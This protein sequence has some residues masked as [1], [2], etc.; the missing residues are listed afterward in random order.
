MCR[1]LARD[2]G[3]ANMYTGEVVFDDGVPGIGSLPAYFP[4]LVKTVVTGGIECV[5]ETESRSPGPGSMQQTVTFADYRRVTPGLLLPGKIHVDESYMPGHT[6]PYGKQCTLDYTLQHSDDKSPPDSA[7]DFQKQLDKTGLLSDTTRKGAP[8]IR[9]EPGKSIES[10]F[11][12]AAENQRRAKIAALKEVRPRSSAG[13][14]GLVAV[15][16]A[17]AGWY[18]YR[19][20]SAR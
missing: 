1:N 3:H 19:R 9:Y 5:T 7:F 18:V 15:I 13:I 14:F 10:Q 16:L 11:N 12:E 2:D 4:G 17:A 6:L 20:S 8:M